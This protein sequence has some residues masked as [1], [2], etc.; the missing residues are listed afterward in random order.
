MYLI[1]LHNTWCV[2]YNFDDGTLFSF[3]NVTTQNIIDFFVTD[4][5]Y[6]FFFMFDVKCKILK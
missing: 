6:L 4:I 3:V 5:L 2:L 1:L